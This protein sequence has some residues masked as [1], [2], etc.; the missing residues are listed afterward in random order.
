MEAHS[1]KQQSNEHKLQEWP[2][3][4]SLQTWHFYMDR[5]S[6]MATIAEDPMGQ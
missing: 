2:L 3:D 5:K 6:K 1:Q 4:G